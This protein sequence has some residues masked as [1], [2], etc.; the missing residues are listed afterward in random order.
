MKETRLSLLRSTPFR[1]AL[2][3]AFLFVLA[4][5]LSGAI[6]YQLMSAGLA[7]RLD[8]S[9][10]QTY[11]VVAVTYGEG[12]KGLIATINDHIQLDSDKD[13]LFSLTDAQGNRLAGNF[14]ASS[15][16]DGFSM[17]AARLPGVPPDTMYRAY[18]GTVGDNNLTVAFSFSETEKLESIVLMSFGWATL[19]SRP[20]TRRYR[21]RTS[22]ASWLMPALKASRSTEPSM[23]CYAS[24]RS[25]PA[26]ARRGSWISMSVAL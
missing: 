10:K 20:P 4:L 26:R 2:T 18:S 16:P 11:S 12:Q 9:I 7:R 22:P 13:Q 21:A 3:F 19:F 8:E 23:R 25:R 1:L 14:T 5:I 17:F 24:P 6:V 15:L